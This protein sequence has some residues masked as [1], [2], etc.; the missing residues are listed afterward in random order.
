MVQDEAN[1]V[2]LPREEEGDYTEHT[3][4]GLE[5]GGEEGPYD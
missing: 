4:T 1:Y 2:P 3:E 5:G